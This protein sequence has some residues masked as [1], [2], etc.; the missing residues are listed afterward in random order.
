MKEDDFVQKTE[1]I[2]NSLFD[3]NK[4]INEIDKNFLKIKLNSSK[5]GY[6]ETI[7]S[8]VYYYFFPAYKKHAKNTVNEF[9]FEKFKTD[10]NNYNEFNY[11]ID[12]LINLKEYFKNKDEDSYFKESLEAVKRFSSYKNIDLFMLFTKDKFKELVCHISAYLTR[13][14]NYFKQVFSIDINENDNFEDFQT[15][16]KLF[17]EEVKYENFVK[18]EEKLNQLTE[19]VKKIKEDQLQKE[20]NLAQIIEEYNDKNNQLIEKVKKIKEDQ[21]QKEKNLAQIIEELKNKNNQTEKIINELKNDKI[22][23]DAEIEKLNEDIEK[24]NE[25]VDEIYLRDT[26]KYSIR[27]F[28]RMFYSKYKFNKKSSG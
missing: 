22:K 8:S 20:K 16:K 15:L 26:M 17:F 19:K 14:L 24:I 1:E 6:D 12:L 7:V 18:N 5:F 9:W 25:K 23:S 21:L 2:L 11:S 27:Y 10:N 4:Q 13:D 3:Q 28:E